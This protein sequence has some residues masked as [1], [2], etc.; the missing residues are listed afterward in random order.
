MLNRSIKKIYSTDDINKQENLTFSDIL[1]IPNIVLLGEPGAGKTHLFTTASQHENGK[2]ITAR[3]FACNAD[4]TYTGKP[5]YIDALDEKRSRDEQI[6][7]ISEIIRL[8]RQYKPAKVRISCRAADWLGETDLELFKPYF[9]ANGGYCVVALEALTEAEIDQIL[10]DHH[11]KNPFEFRE[12]AYSKGVSSLLNNP[13]T[14]IML[15]RLVSNGQWPKSKND[16]YENATNLL[17]TE[18]NKNHQHKP[19]AHYVVNDLKQAAGAACAILLIADIEAISLLES[20]NFPYTEIPYPKA[21]TVLAALTKRSFVSVD[22]EQVTYSH[23]T[24]AEYLAACWLVDTIRNGLP[25]SRVCSL[26]CV[27][28]H[29]APELRGLYAWLTQLLP[30]HADFLMATDPYGVLVQ[31]DVA[32]LTLSSRNALLNALV[33][34]SEQDPWFR[35]QDWTSEPLGALS[36]PEMAAE[37]KALLAREPKQYHLRS[38]VLNAI[39]YGEPQPSLEEE[40][41]HIFCDNNEVY[42]ARSDAYDALVHAIPNGKE[43]IVKAVREQLKNSN[44]ELRLKENVMA[45]MFEGYFNL[46]DVALLISDFETHRKEDNVV[47]NLSV[48]SHSL[49]LDILP[50]LLDRICHFGSNKRYKHQDIEFFTC[51]ILTRV[52]SSKKSIEL[53]RLWSWFS[54]TEYY[55]SNSS[56]KDEIKVWFSENPKTVIGLFKIT[57]TQYGHFR[58]IRFFWHKFQELTKFTLTNEQLIDTAFSFIKGKKSCDDKEQFIFKLAFNLT[59]CHTIDVDRFTLLYDYGISHPELAEL[60]SELCYSHIADWPIENAKTKNVHKKQQ[61]TRQQQNRTDFEKNK[62]LIRIGQHHGWL[63]YLGQLYFAKFSEVDKKQTPKQRLEQE[64]GKQNTVLAL[65]GLRAAFNRTD[66]PTSLEIA[67][68]YAENKYHE[69]WYAIPVGITE[70]W[71]YQQNL[72]AYPESALKSA[73]AFNILFPSFFHVEGNAQRQFEPDWQQALFQYKPELV[74][75]VYLEIIESQLTIK[76]DYVTGIWVICRHQQ[77]ASNRPAIVLKLLTDYPNAPTQVLETLL[78]TAVSLPEIASD[79]LKLIQ[80]VLQPKTRVRLKQKALWLCAGFYMDFECFKD[81]VIW[82]VTKQKDFIWILIS[83]IDDVPSRSEKKPP[84]Y[85]LPV[86][87]GFLIELVAT[88]FPYVERKSGGW[89]GSQNPW[90][91][92]DFIKRNINQLSTQTDNESI[93]TLSR[94]IDK[95]ELE[96]YHDHLKHAFANQAALLREQHF[97]RPNWQQAI[98]SLKNGKPA[99]T[100]DL[101]ALTVEHLNDVANR[102]VNE[103]TD[104]FKFFWNEDSYARITE[105]KPEESCRDKLVELLRPKF[106]PFGISVE[107]EGHMARDKRADIVLKYQTEQTLPIEVKRNYHADLW[108]ACENQLDRLYTR[109]P[110]AKG[111]GIYL[112][113]WFGDQRPRSMPNPTNGLQ[114]PK[115]AQEL[116]IALRSL[117]KSSDQNRLAI[118]VIDVT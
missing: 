7:S 83:F 34:L 45:D 12:T 105:P 81:M 62:D 6:D 29:P 23:R 86:Q 68:F 33:K 1:A 59:I 101:H 106:A 97:D 26:L 117:I 60:L 43:L 53:K 37:L 3:S 51:E 47:G 66:L 63:A 57:L 73:L 80:Q 31:G 56:Y 77:L 41:L 67:Q 36:T 38:V 42:G 46:D 70:N 28:G 13:Q 98:E 110:Q 109:D 8:V 116:E 25:I 58:D 108:T 111:Y 99:H 118:V 2:L 16:L 65:E 94:L 82:G 79:L 20:E 35:G 19:L 21:D 52:L 103:N 95:P 114:K 5:V 96:S 14:L 64:L 17:L 30:E 85:F 44:D 113:F 104:L 54:T 76:R 84:E 9:D 50:E 48:L 92:T 4:D 91:A 61:T 87:L 74:Q 11:I 15:A 49:P 112:V 89:V 102:I 10:T 78:S 69:W 18:H 72:N 100:A 27:D 90:D 22:Q 93:S 55:S 115:T 39:T 32:C 107:P 40:L 24:I 75:S 88:Q 71:F